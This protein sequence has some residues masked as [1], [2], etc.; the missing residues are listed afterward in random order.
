MRLPQSVRVRFQKPQ[1]PQQKFRMH[2][3]ALLLMLPGRATLRHLS[4]YRP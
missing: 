3:L 2:L 4:R 1:K